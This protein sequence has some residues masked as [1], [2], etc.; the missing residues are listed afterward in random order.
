MSPTTWLAGTFVAAGHRHHRGRDD[1][2][3]GVLETDD[4]RHRH[5]C[6]LTE[7]QQRQA[8]PHIADIAVGAGKRLDGAIGERIATQKEADQEENE[9]DQV[10]RADLAE[11]E[12]G[13]GQLLDRGAGDELEEQRRQS[14]VDD[15]R[16][17]PAERFGRLFRHPRGQITDEDQPEEGQQQCNDIGHRFPARGPGRIGRRFSV[18]RFASGLERSAGT[19][20]RPK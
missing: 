17:H 16:I 9:E 4:Q 1:E 14:R 13:P 11:D 12:V 6:R 15:E 19:R 10:G 5:R 8:R 7:S 20:L 2:M 3:R 18:S